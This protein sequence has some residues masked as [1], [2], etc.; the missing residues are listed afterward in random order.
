[1]YS[2]LSHQ[3]LAELKTRLENEYNAL[4]AKGLS[5]DMSRGKPSGDQLNLSNQLLNVDLGDYKCEAGFDCRNYG[6]LDGIEEAKRLFMPLLGTNEPDNI[7]IGGNSSLQLMYDVIAKFMLFGVSEQAEPW[8]RGIKFLCPAP[9]YDRHFA[10]LQAFGI[11]MITIKLNKDGPDMDT[12]EALAAADPAIKGI[13]CVPM[14]SNPDGF[15]YSEETVKRLAAMKAAAPDF[16]IM[17]DNAYGVH[18]LTDTPLCALSVNDECAK[19]GNPD[20]AYVFASTSKITFAGGGISAMA[21]SAANTAFMKKLLSVQTIGF[22]KINQLRHAKFFKDF[23]GILAHMDKHKEI[24][25]PKFDV[26]CKML[27]A[28]LTPYKLGEWHKP[29]G[30]YFISFNGL[31]GTAKRIIELC[32]QAGVILTAAGAAF[33]YGNDPDDKNIRIAPTF[34]PVSELTSAMEVF[35]ASV[36]L[37]SIEKMLAN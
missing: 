20:R 25:R 32:K 27:E 8:Q 6:L 16:R 35:C 14:Y 13:Y 30:G 18:H 9:G 36:K 19:A 5:L 31:N 26:V 7:I 33:P 24:L 22:D 21:S 10:I 11:D 2:N 23:A 28:E 4:K 1:M 12:A 37:A 29:E 17:W 3:E 15:T 34:P